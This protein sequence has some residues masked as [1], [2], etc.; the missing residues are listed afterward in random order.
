MAWSAVIFTP[1]SM[2]KGIEY[3][4]D[5]DWV[6]GCTALVECDDGN[7]QILHWADEIKARKEREEQPVRLMSVGGGLDQAA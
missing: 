1:P 3:Y 7:M 6:E 5:G 2:I 4:N